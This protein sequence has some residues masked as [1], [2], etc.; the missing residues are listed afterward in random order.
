M[1]E[2]GVLFDGFPSPVER[3][4]NAPLEF[5]TLSTGR[6]FHG[7]F[8]FVLLGAPRRRGRVHRGFGSF[9]P[10]IFSRSGQNPK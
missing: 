7:A 3:V 5:S 10:E 1:W 6:H 9:F 8:H 4:G 2:S